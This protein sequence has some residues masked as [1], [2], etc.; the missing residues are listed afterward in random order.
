MFVEG[1]NFGSLGWSAIRPFLNEIEKIGDLLFSEKKYFWISSQQPTLDISLR[2]MSGNIIKLYDQET[3]QIIGQIDYASSL[4]MVHEGAVYMQQ[5]EDYLV[6]ELDIANG[7]AILEKKPL[8]YFTDA[9]RETKIEIHDVLEKSSFKNIDISYG[10]IEVNNKIVAFDEIL[11]ESN[12]KLATKELDLPP[13]HLDTQAM[14][15]PFGE[16][17]I[18]SLREQNL[19]TNDQNDY[20]KNWKEIKQKIRLRDHF[21][22]QSCGM[23]EDKISHHVHHIKPFRMFDH[24][25]EANKASNLI[26]LCPK[27]HNRVELNVKVQSGLGGLKYISKN[28]APLFL[29]CDFEDIDVFTEAASNLANAR[30]IFL[31]YDNIPYGIGLSRHMFGILPTFFS[32]VLQHISECP[33]QNGCP[34]CVGPEAEQ[35][36]G[37]KVETVAIL[38]AILE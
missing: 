12:V 22:C 32:H 10:N 7:K 18:D 8:N 14:W 4:W 19:W 25:E 37:G 5:G 15:F 36:Y 20:G 17:L 31:F 23:P 26:T 38:K 33:C 2:N 11:W 1:E 28:M 21:V 27:C 30:P 16:H 29:M 24:I 13:I 3:N 34:S 9:K 35:G 6:K